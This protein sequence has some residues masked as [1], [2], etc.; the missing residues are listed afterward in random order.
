MTDGRA[1]ACD[2]DFLAR[3]EFNGSL[4]AEGKVAWCGSLGKLGARG[5]VGRGCKVWIGDTVRDDRRGGGDFRLSVGVRCG[6]L[7]W[8]WRLSSKVRTRLST[9]GESKIDTFDGRRAL[10]AC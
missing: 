1:W 5:D 7:G 2:A 10:N 3:S 9:G 4:G 6:N 8:R